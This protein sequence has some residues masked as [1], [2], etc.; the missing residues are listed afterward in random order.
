VSAGSASSTFSKSHDARAR[1]LVG[2]SAATVALRGIRSRTESSPKNS[3]GPSRATTVP[4]G[5]YWLGPSYLGSPA[6]AT[7]VRTNA[8][9]ALQIVYGAIV[10]WNYAD[11][12]PPDIVA[13]TAGF[14]KTFPLPQGGVARGY[15]NTRGLVVVDVEIGGKRV[16]LVSR[17]KVDTFTAAQRLRKRA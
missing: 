8:G 16:A 11:Y 17:G 15:F 7:L 5:A 14:A 10:V 1:Q 6:R 12:L 3:P 13:A 4:H 2:A 9:N